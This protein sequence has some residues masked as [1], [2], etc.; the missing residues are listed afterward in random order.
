MRDFFPPAPGG[1]RTFG[2]AAHD[3]GAI[4]GSHNGYAADLI[5]LKSGEGAHRELAASAQ[6]RRARCARR[7]RRA[8]TVHGSGQRRSRAPL[9]LRASECRARLVRALDTSQR[10]RSVTRSQLQGPT[11]ADPQP[12]ARWRH[13]DPLSVSAAA[14]PRS[15]EWRQPAHPAATPAVGRTCAASWCQRA[16]PRAAMRACGPP[17]RRADLRVRESRQ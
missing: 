6:L 14:Y 13:I 11:G 17:A 10:D 8:R 9:P 7:Q 4:R 12:P 2:L 16:L 5:V 15:R 1:L 3:P